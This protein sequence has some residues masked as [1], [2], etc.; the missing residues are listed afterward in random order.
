MV[1]GVAAATVLPENFEMQ[2]IR[3]HPRPT[4][5]QVGPGNVL[6]GPPGDS[7]AKI[8]RTTWACGVRL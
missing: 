8:V 1:L 3:P 4:E 2:I 7:H 5:L 6:T